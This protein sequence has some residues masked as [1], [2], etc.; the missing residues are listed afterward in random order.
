VCD[1]PVLAV[2]EIL[3]VFVTL[4]DED[5]GEVSVEQS[6]LPHEAMI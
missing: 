6:L 4:E 3:I 2:R 5:A 1:P